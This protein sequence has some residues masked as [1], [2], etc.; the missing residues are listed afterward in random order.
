LSSEREPALL[1]KNGTGQERIDKKTVHTP[2]ITAEKWWH[3]R[4]LSGGYRFI[5]GGKY[6]K[7]RITGL[8]ICIICTFIVS[9]SAQQKEKA[10]GNPEASS[11]SSG[12]LDAEGK[13]LDS[14]I[15]NLNEGIAGV[16]QK[17]KLM[18]NKDIKIIP[19]QVDYSV[20]KDYILIERHMFMRDMMDVKVV[21][22]KRKSVKLYGSG[23]SLAKIE[24]MIYERDYNNA[25]EHYVEIIDPSPMT[26]G[27]DDVIIKQTFNKKLVFNKTLGEMKNTT[28]F[29]VRNDFKRNFYIPHLTYFYNTVLSIAETYSKGAK[30]TDS[31]VTDFLQ[32][33]TQY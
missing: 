10:K 26:E 8:V 28:A 24:S 32:R 6:M 31:S 23:G 29:P 1:S 33:S 9:V 13:N 11:L 12:N 7:F 18:E 22:E 14:I 20:E 3:D 25:N 21:G 17:Y 15:K 4:A 19:Y 30:D 5:F 27:L 16:L 2:Q